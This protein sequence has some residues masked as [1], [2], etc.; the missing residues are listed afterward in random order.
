MQTS[1]DGS[2]GK[3]TVAHFIASNVMGGVEIATLRLTSATNAQFRHVAFLWPGAAVLKN[4][5]EKQGVETVTYTPPTPSL[6]HGIRFYKQS[7]EVARQLRG[8]KADIVHFADKFAAYYTSLAALLAHTKTICHVRL[9]HPQLSLRDRLS[10]LP[11]QNYIFVSAEAMRTF[12]LH[13]PESRAR[14]IYDSIVVSTA[15]MTD[16]NA[17]V[18][19]EFGIEPG[20]ALV[21]SVARVAPQKD[22]PALVTAA[23]EVLS[24]YPDTRF[25]IVG[26]HSSDPDHRA[27][28][29]A[30]LE[31]LE[32]LGIKDSFIF[33]GYRNDVPR[34]LAAMDISVL[35]THREGFPLSILESMALRKPVI[36]TAVGGVPEIVKHGVTGYLHQHSDSKQLAR[37]II[38]LI[39]SPEELNRIANAGYE[40]VR[41]NFSSQ[42]YMVEMS[43]AYLDAMRS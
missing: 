25:L 16:S 21:G 10:L 27:H 8:V 3:P 20:C 4:L 33:T 30:V 24:R 23:A 22:F 34:L 15:D 29:E 11:V 41:L 31:Q 36:A 35:C 28:F 9:S 26:E 17:A 32:D 43:K 13:L 39:E 40:H 18:R 12:G 1:P 19:R 14:V 38:S 6:R 37:E 42:K 5:F 2:N 7:L